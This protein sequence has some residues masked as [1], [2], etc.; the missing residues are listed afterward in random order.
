MDS[1]S[2]DTISK[3]VEIIKKKDSEI[4]TRFL[5][6]VHASL[7][8]EQWLTN[9]HTNKLYNAVEIAQEACKLSKLPYD[10]KE[11][12]FLSLRLIDFERK[13]Y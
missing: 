9:I 10:G 2:K 1:D 12:T 3:N 7:G 6:I 11:F 4:V 5:Y 13:N 8:K